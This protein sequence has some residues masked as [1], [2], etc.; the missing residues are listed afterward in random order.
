M[1]R[2]ILASLLSLCLLTGLLPFATV[3]ARAA[4]EGGGTVTEEGSDDGNNAGASEAN[5][6]AYLVRKTLAAILDDNATLHAAMAAKENASIQVSFSDIDSCDVREKAAIT[7]MVQAGV[8]SGTDNNLFSPNDTAT[9]ATA[10]VFIWKILGSKTA[11]TQSIPYSDIAS[12]AWYTSAIYSLYDDGILTENDIV[13]TGNDETEKCFGPEEGVTADQV[14]TWCGRIE[15]AGDEGGEDTAPEGQ[16][17]RAQLADMIYGNNKLQRLIGLAAWGDTGELHFSDIGSCTQAQQEAIY[18]MAGARVLSGTG[19]GTFGPD[20]PA[21]RAQAAVVLWRAMG[22]RSNREPANLPVDVDSSAWYAAA[23]SCLRALDIVEGNE[24]FYPDKP[25]KAEELDAWLKAYDQLEESVI[26]E[27]TVGNGLSRVEMVAL[28]YNEYKA[29]LPDASGYTADFNDISGCTEEQKAILGLFSSGL[30]VANGLGPPYKG[31]FAPFAAASNAQTVAILSR[32]I[33][34]IEDQ[35]KTAGGTETLSLAEEGVLWG[36]VVCNAE[37]WYADALAILEE[38]GLTAA[39]KTVTANPDAPVVEEDLQAWS[40]AL[41]PAAP[42]FSLRPGTYSSA[43]SV[44]LTAEEGAVI[45][46][47]TDGSEPTADSAVYSGAITVRRSTTIKAIAVKDSLP[48]D[49]AS[50]A[51]TIRSGSSGGD[52]DDDYG[53]STSGSSTTTPAKPED[54]VTTETTENPDGSTTTT[55]TDTAAG[56]VTET[57]EYT[58]G[59]T[60]AVETKKDGTVTTTSTAASGVTVR[61]VDEPGKDVTAAV[62]IPQGVGEAAVTIPADVNYGMVAMDAVTGEIVKLSVPTADG[63]VVKLDGSA[64]LILVDNSKDFTDTDGHWAEDAID[65]ASAHGLFGGTGDGST[66]SPQD[67]MT[68]AMLVTVL[69]RFDGEDTSGGSVWYE[70]GMAWAVSRG[71]SDGSDPYGAITREQLAAMLCRYAGSP[72][73]SGSLDGFADAH[74]VS[75]YALDAMRWAVEAG[76][77]GGMGDGALAPQAGAT[78]AQVATML[79]RYVEYLTR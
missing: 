67:A 17:T 70:K 73:A 33:T 69:A 72:A 19:E 55:V 18:A 22:C 58:D 30:H 42:V 59:S 47:T 57:T 40:S 62:T 53:G 49:T 5:A 46:Y 39:V 11:K 41:K 75:D 43:Q 24:K 7:L 23:V 16:L 66:F 78:R 8:I 12:D 26:E 71:V 4:S 65:F 9:R 68:R 28:F 2:R 31:D 74:S 76:L 64:N 1:K 38:R 77:I 32:L 35:E 50:A 52:D 34:W 60:L 37:A 29:M 56:T 51:Y 3:Q 79:M 20:K 6:P 44:T 15:N 48:S 36:T 45:H 21:V 61:T 54:T 27:K 10:A 13:S 14:N 25:V 63:M